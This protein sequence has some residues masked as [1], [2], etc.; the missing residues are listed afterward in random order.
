MA[1]RAIAT[2]NPQDQEESRAA[3]RYLETLVSDARDALRAGDHPE[4]HLAEL[5]NSLRFAE[6]ETADVLALLIFLAA[7]ERIENE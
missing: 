5:S 2:R 6:W 3:T 7:Q 1:Y 4:D